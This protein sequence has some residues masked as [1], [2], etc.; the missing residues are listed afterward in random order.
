MRE[1]WWPICI[2][3]FLEALLWRTCIALGATGSSFD[4]VFL[5]RCLPHCS[6]SVSIGIH[7][8]VPFVKCVVVKSELLWL[9]G[10][11]LDQQQQHPAS[12]FVVVSMALVCIGAMCL[13]RKLKSTLGCWRYWLLSWITWQLWLVWGS[14][15][16]LSSLAC[17]VVV[18]VCCEALALLG[19][20]HVHSRCV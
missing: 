6:F 14:I 18:W 1:W 15:V 9:W 13:M 7:R 3:S 19:L 5:M 10:W 8:V 20:L 11:C 2:I 12:S 16:C 17:G 4:H